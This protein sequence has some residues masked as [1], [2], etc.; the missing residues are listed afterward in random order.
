M[1]I[2]RRMLENEE[3]Q[4]VQPGRVTLNKNGRVEAVSTGVERD[5]EI[6]SPFGYCFSLPK[7]SEMLLVQSA[8]G[9]AAIGVKHSAENIFPGEIKISSPSGAYIYLKKDGSV[10]INGLEIGKDGVIND[11]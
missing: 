10:V 1:W 9:Q 3:K 8:D 4:T 5:V 6:Y 7:G 11:K 2:S